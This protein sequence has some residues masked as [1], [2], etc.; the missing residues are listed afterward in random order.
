M[1]SLVESIKRLYKV[2]RI[3]IKQIKAIY[4]KGNITSDEYSYITGKKV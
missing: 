2:K 3:T 1:R 4:E